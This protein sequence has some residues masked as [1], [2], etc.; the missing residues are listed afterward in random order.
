MNIEA[1]ISLIFVNLFIK[2]NFFLYGTG[3]LQRAVAQEM[4]RVF[5][6]GNEH[7]YVIERIDEISTLSSTLS[8]EDLVILISL[9]GESDNAQYFPKKLDLKGVPFATITGFEENSISR[10]SEESIYVHTSEINLGNGI[11][12]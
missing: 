4:R 11:E 3:S 2:E 12:Y 8:N 7:F 5:F 9:K 6:T 1:V 10:L